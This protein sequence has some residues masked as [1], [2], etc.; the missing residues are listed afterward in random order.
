MKTRN[1]WAGCGCW[2]SPERVSQALPEPLEPKSRPE[3]R[4]PEGLRCVVRLSSR[5]TV[6]NE[7]ALSASQSLTICRI[8]LKRGR[9]E[10]G[11]PKGQKDIQIEQGSKSVIFLELFLLPQGTFCE[12]VLSAWRA[13]RAGK[14]RLSLL[15]RPAT[16]GDRGARFWFST[17][18]S[19]NFILPSQY[20]R[21]DGRHMGVS[22]VCGGSA[23]RVA[24]CGRKA[25]AATLGKR[26]P[27]GLLE[28]IWASSSS[29]SQSGATQDKDG[30]SGQGSQKLVSVEKVDD[31]IVVVPA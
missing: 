7:M 24:S 5:W 22:E 28:D 21:R 20:K 10:T 11:A 9:S 6:T 30:P 15:I 13:Y 17:I 27:Q 18:S 16:I 12:S 23:G 29:A 4:L 2:T 14:P 26:A 31:A 19:I 25:T 3:V 1:G 8:V